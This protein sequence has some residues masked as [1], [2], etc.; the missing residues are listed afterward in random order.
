MRLGGLTAAVA[1]MRSAGLTYE[2]SSKCP[3]LLR[4]PVTNRSR[5]TP[6]GRPISGLGWQT[7]PA[8]RSLARFM[9]WLYIPTTSTTGAKTIANDRL[10]TEEGVFHPGLA[11]VARDFLPLAPSECF[12]VGDRV[13]VRT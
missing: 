12:H 6:I 1:P 13:I 5:V 11:M 8:A 4:P 2:R 7:S 10:V 9:R 3:V